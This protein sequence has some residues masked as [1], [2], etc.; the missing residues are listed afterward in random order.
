VFTDA[1]F[2]RDGRGG[3]GVVWYRPTKAPRPCVLWSCGVA[4]ARDVNQ[5]E[6]GAIFWALMLSNPARALRVH[7][8]S[9]ASLDMIAR[10]T[11]NPRYHSLVTGIRRVCELRD[12]P[13]E[14]TKV[15]A[16]AGVAGN[17]MADALARLGREGSG[18]ACTWLPTAPLLLK[19]PTLQGMFADNFELRGVLPM[20]VPVG[21]HTGALRD[22]GM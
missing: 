13:T 20:I 7:T 1:S 8:D 16:H 9:Q 22:K 10:H 6:L 21:A 3:L 19:A 17:E 2:A 5:C 11:A 15:K 4:G 14:F 18:Q 12:K